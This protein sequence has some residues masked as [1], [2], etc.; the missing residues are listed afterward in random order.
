MSNLHKR[1]TEIELSVNEAE[2]YRAFR[3]EPSRRR[4]SA[5]V[6][7][8]TKSEGDLGTKLHSI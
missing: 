7:L 8:Y 1:Q 3:R 5:V 4:R 2:G 6:R